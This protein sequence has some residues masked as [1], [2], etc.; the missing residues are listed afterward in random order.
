MCAFSIS[1]VF[2]GCA[3]GFYFPEA[4]F[5][6]YINQDGATNSM[7]KYY[8]LVENL[9]LIAKPSENPTCV[10]GLCVIRDTECSFDVFPQA[11]GL[12]FHL[13]SH[14]DQSSGF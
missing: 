8:Y 10:M 7:Y 14:M 11:L 3:C 5:F 1:F 9:L 13:V 4:L 2:V 12:S 6:L